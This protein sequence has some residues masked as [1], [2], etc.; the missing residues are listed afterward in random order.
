M[1]CHFLLTRRFLSM[2]NLRNSLEFYKYLQML[3]KFLVTH[4]V[5][6][7]FFTWVEFTLKYL[8]QIHKYKPKILFNTCFSISFFSFPDVSLVTFFK[9]NL[10]NPWFS[11]QTGNRFSEQGSEWQK[12][13]S[14]RGCFKI[15]WSLKKNA[16]LLI[17]F[18]P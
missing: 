16:S 5:A 11:L 1:V 9:S 13:C 17:F 8:S 10:T 15:L 6:I 14:L 2:T 12:N 3:C 18:W 4:Q 7:F